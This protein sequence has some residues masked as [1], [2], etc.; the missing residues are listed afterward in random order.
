VEQ[1]QLLILIQ[2]AQVAAQ[3]RLVVAVQVLIVVQA[4]L[5]LHRQL[6]DHQLPVRAAVAVDSLILVA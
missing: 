3:V 2:A 5:A 4:E 6:Q 1:T